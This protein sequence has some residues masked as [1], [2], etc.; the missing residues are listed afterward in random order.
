MV[1]KFDAAIVFLTA[2]CVGLLMLIMCGATLAGVFA[3]YVLNDAIS[4]SEEVA[5]YAMIWMSFLGGGL[6]FRYSGHIAIDILVKSLPAGL[7]RKTI[8]GLAHLVVVTFLAMLA[9]YGWTLMMRGNYMTTAALRIP[10][11]LP[12]AAIPVG[13]VMMIYH[14]LAANILLRKH[15]PAFPKK[16]LET[17]SV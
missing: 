3:R 5:R 15:Q 11:S 13:A 6:V 16:S 17:T 2:L 12:Y 4:W 10:M 1:R 7:V 8:I 14:L 9:W